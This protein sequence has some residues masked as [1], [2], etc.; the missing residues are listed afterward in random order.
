MNEEIEA[1]FQKQCQKLVKDYP[2]EV[3]EINGKQY[4]L[5]GITK[6]EVKH[7]FGILFDVLKECIDSSPE[8]SAVALAVIE[9]LEN[10]LTAIRSRNY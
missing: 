10:I 7:I 3:H 4:H 6:E 8:A 5:V 1:L 2:E 9:S